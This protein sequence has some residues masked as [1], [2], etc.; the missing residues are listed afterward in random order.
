MWPPVLEFLRQ[1]GVAD[2]NAN[3]VY[4]D[5]LTVEAGQI[6]EGDVIVYSGNADIESGGAVRGDLV[7]YS[8]DIEIESGAN[9][10]G[11]VAAFSGDIDVAGTVEGSIASWSGDVTLSDSAY[12]G[13]DISVL[14]G[15]IDKEQSAYI[16]G[17]LVQGPSFKLPM[18]RAGA[19]SFNLTPDGEASPLVQLQRGA[20]SFAQRLAALVGRVVLA[21]VITV[22]VAL[23]A[24][25]LIA[26]RPT[27]VETV[28]S[29]MVAQT[30]LSFAVGL[31]TNLVLLFLTGILVI[32]ICL[33]PL[34]LAP[35]LILLA[36][37]LAGWT[38]LSKEVGQRLV[39]YS[40]APVQPVVATALGALVVTGVPTL[41]WSFGG[42]FRFMAFVTVLLVASAGAGAVLLPWL[43][44][45]RALTAGDAADL[46]DGEAV[47]TAKPQTA[48][49]AATATGVAAATTAGADD[50]SSGS[51]TSET[52]E[53]AEDQRSEKIESEAAFEDGPDLDVV[54]ET[55][56][57]T[58]LP[59]AAP[60]ATTETNE[61]AITQ[62]AGGDDDF[63]QIS[64]IGP[65][66]ERR[67]KAANVR[68]YAALASLPASELADILGWS[69]ERVERE[70]LLGQAAELANT[71]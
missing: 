40:H 13:G 34:A 46:N 18:P 25:G 57:M 3:Q 43:N 12:V 11:D 52:S 29:T 47:A 62:A 9:V 27:L 2:L 26:V 59:A 49:V 41:L 20:P 16:G 48:V 58:E 51:D 61:P 21:M 31:V 24:A 68:T 70:M 69:M 56:L 63:T 4:R 60:L 10:S 65:A 19:F 71:G 44:R 67:L 54:E 39:D 64:G 14:S 7:V 55:D 35:I 17:N 66:F 5:D 6:I 53:V 42:C 36:L 1:N 37:N 28:K 50:R 15:E 8:G 32:T 22:V 33:S 23:L 45:Q 38:A 30:A